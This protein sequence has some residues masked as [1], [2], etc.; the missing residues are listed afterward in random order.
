MSTLSRREER[1]KRADTEIV[2]D[3]SNISDLDQS[4]S[5]NSDSDADDQQETKTPA[6][7]QVGSSRM[8]PRRARV[9][10]EPDDSWNYI[11]MSFN[12]ACFEFNQRTQDENV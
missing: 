5:Q 10:E 1:R 11:G 8:R 3:D 4:E 9:V 2:T 12:S 6:V 7:E